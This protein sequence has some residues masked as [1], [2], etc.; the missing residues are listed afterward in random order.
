MSEPEIKEDFSGMIEVNGVKVVSADS[1][2]PKSQES[3]PTQ[4]PQIQI[5]QA[6]QT[7]QTQQNQQTQ[8]PQQ[9]QQREHQ[10]QK[11]HHQP[12]VQNGGD[13]GILTQLM[14]NKKIII[15]FIVLVAA[16]FLLWKF[17]L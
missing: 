11:I 1:D 15:A 4:E 10:Y 5:Q 8:Q 12:Y 6:Q 13:E 9:S 16:G 3:Q 17:Y 7:Q 14:H 2:E